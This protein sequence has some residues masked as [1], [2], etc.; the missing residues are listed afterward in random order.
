M[1]AEYRVKGKQSDLDSVVLWANFLNEVPLDSFGTSRALCLGMA[2][3]DCVLDSNP[4][5]AESNAKPRPRVLLSEQDPEFR[6]MLAEVLLENGFEVFMASSQVQLFDYLWY[7]RRD[8]V[9]WPEPDIIVSDLRLSGWSAPELL[10]TL[11]YSLVRTP[12]LFI[13]A[14]A[15]DLLAVRGE[16]QRGLEVLEKPFDLDELLARIALVVSPIR[17]RW[18]ALSRSDAPSLP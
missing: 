15:D 17:K 14:N 18:D 8:P 10:R 9:N 3:N 6:T 12:V 11:E 2:S 5:P 16:R 1:A 13:T 4:G 7:C